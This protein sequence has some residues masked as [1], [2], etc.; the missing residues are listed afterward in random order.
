MPQISLPPPAET[1]AAYPEIAEPRA[2]TK[3]I[4]AYRAFRLAALVE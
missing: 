4:H 2:Y 1:A 3:R